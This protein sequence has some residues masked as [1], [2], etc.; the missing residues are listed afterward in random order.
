MLTLVTM[1]F[2]ALVACFTDYFYRRQGTAYF[3]EIIHIVAVLL[4]GGCLLMDGMANHHYGYMTVLS[5]TLLFFVATQSGIITFIESL[6]YYAFCLVVFVITLTSNFRGSRLHSTEQQSSGNLLLYIASF[7]ISGMTL[8]IH[9]YIFLSSE[10]SSFN[11]SHLGARNAKKIESFVDRLLPKHIKDQ[12]I[13]HGSCADV[14]EDVTLLFADIVGFTA[15]CAGKS[16]SE[17]VEMLSKLFTAFDKEC[18]KLNLYKVYT[19]GDCYV[20]MSYLDKNNRKKVELECA[21]M[22]E[23]AFKMIEIIARVRREVNFSG[24]HMRIGIHTGKVIGGVIGTGIIRYDLYGRDVLIANKMES[25]GKPDAVHIS[26][27]TKKQLE[28]A[29]TRYKFVP[30]EDLYIKPLE[31]TLKTFFLER[32]VLN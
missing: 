28:A 19:I 7:S 23:M 17:V 21:D 24:L 27:A 3:K 29:A 18:N 2:V 11:N 32:R 8:L 15:Y 13:A 16:P 26:E 1:S 31:T 22:A 5:F 30:D 20:V 12:V 25:S 14:A 4:A 6:R 9:H 10:I